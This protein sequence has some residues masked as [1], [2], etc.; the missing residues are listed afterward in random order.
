[1]AGLNIM[2]PD[3]RCFTFDER[4]NGY[5]RGEGIG[6]VVLKRV[7]DA[8]RDN[9]TIRAVIRGTRSN[10]DGRTQGRLDSS[11]PA[12]AVNLDQES[13]CQARSA[14]SRTFPGCTEPPGWTSTAPPTSSATAQVRK[15]GT[16]SSFTPSPSRSAR[17]GYPRIRY[18]SAR[19]NPT[20]ATS[21]GALAWLVSSRACSSWKRGLYPS[22]VTLRFRT[23]E[24]TLRRSRSR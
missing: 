8:I 19:S 10:Q 14:R 6:V 12:M 18:L 21:R 20:L 1:M 22:I 7:E 15:P 13:P 23:A 4:A 5:G 16:F 3:G 2:S 24:S 9:D 11:R 17:T